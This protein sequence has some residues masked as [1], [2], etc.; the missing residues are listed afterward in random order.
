MKYGLAL[1]V[2]TIALSIFFTATSACAATELTFSIPSED[3]SVALTEFSRTTGLQVAADPA[4]LRGRRSHAVQGRLSPEGALKT[5]TVGSGVQAR[6]ANGAV[7]IQP[8]AVRTPI[9]YAPAPSTVRTLVAATDEAAPSPSVDEVVVSGY[10]ASLQRA[11]DLKRRAVGSEDDILAQDIAAF[12][13]LNLAE[14]LQRVPGVSITRDAGEGRQITVRG[15]GPDFTRTELNGME[16]LGNTASGMDNR[17][18]VSRTR[19]FDYSLF[20]SELFNRVTVQKS[21]A[22]EQD[23]GGIAGTVL[24]Y[25]AKPFDFSGSKLVVS[26]SGQTNE[27]TNGVTPRVVAL[28]SNRWGDFGALAS[29]AYSE[30]RS[31][32]FGYRNWGWGP[33]HYNAKNVGSEISAADA[34]QL[35]ATGASRLF[36]P[37]AESPSSWYTDRKRLGITTAFQYQPSDNFHVGL[38]LLYGKLKN[39]RDDYAIAAGGTNALTGDVT[40]T[41][42]IHSAVI[43]GNSLVA[44]SYT[45]VDLRTEH[46]IQDDSTEFS[47]AVLSGEWKPM[48]RLTVDFQGGYQRS[49]YSQPH[50]DKVFLEALNQPFSFDMRSKIPTNTYGFDINDPNSWQLMRLDA[51]ANRIDSRYSNGKLDLAWQANNISTVKFGAEYKDFTNAGF[52]EN[53]KVFYN[54]PTLTNLS[55]SLKTTV[56]VDTLLP[57]I[58]GD[59]IPTFNQIGQSIDLNRS[60]LSPGSD[61]KVEEKTW[62]GYLQ[63]DLDT[64]ILGFPTR[65]NVGVRYYTTDTTSSGTLNT[66]TTLSPVSI[67]TTD[68]GW[69]PAAN[70]AVNLNP[71]LIVRFSANRNVNRAPLANLAAAGT[72]TTAPFGGTISVGNP[73]LKPYRATSLEG[74]VEYYFDHKG[75]V[76]LGVFY[77]DMDSFITTET[78]VVPYSATGYPLSFLLPGQDGSIPYNYSRPINGDGASIKG[79]EAA[80][81]HDFSFLPAPFDKFGLVANVTYATGHQNALINGASFRIPLVNLSKVSTNATLYYE[82]DRWGVRVSDA[83]RS[84]YLISAGSN[85]NVGE[86]IAASNNVDAEAYVNINRRLKLTLEGLNLTNQAIKQYTD[87]TAKRLE[88]YT[89]SGRT[90]TFGAK[91]EF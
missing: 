51:Q 30:N 31:N 11:Q 78:T 41:Q 43:Q 65:A 22:A 67:S 62:A 60:F 87:L 53:N 74:S 72:L 33:V 42:V 77:K 45:G 59:V 90:F 88:V 3:L 14:S 79:V 1:G 26:A 71:D 24:L 9:A 28:A 47:Q 27:N 8:G 4:M 83:Y 20:A 89:T 37:Q 56:P 81:E 44:G 38:D 16:V 29:I 80:F 13:D 82:T 23:E 40:G 49:L 50:F 76:S 52:Q 6:V 10:R 12:P 21:Y 84:R 55:N 19:A 54:A 2:S 32:E 61:Y 25:T 17:G 68:K 66:G 63:Y 75:Y 57:Y 35:E 64:E 85:G 48:D 5:L 7:L 70:I 15:L 69:L 46:N 58:V 91:Y 34:A 73:F 86:Y 39:N 18:N 36:A